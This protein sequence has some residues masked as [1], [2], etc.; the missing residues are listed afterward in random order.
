MDEMTRRDF[1]R[2]VNGGLVAVGVTTVGIPLLAYLY[3]PDTSEVPAERMRVAALDELPVGKGMTVKYGRYPALVIHTDQG[4]RAYSAI[5]THFACLVK[6]D[7]QRG[8]IMCPCHEAFFNPHDGSVIS[9]PPPRPLTRF[10]VAVDRGVIYV[11]GA[12]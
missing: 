9:G 10:P 12:A 7:E 8:Q 6:W 2:L 3:P 11:G 5:C 4:L 1:L